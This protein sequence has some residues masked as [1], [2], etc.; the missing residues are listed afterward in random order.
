MAIIP[1]QFP[2]REPIADKS[3]IV[4]EPWRIWFRD[5]LET[6]QSQPVVTSPLV[7]LTGKTAS[8]T[9]TPFTTGTLAAGFYRFSYYATVTTAA[10]VSSSL[11]VTATWTD[12]GVVQTR[13]SAAMTGNTTAT[14]QSEVWPLH[15]DASSP[16]SYS[17][18]YASNVAATM[19]YALYLVLETVIAV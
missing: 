11:I 12:H 6:Q 13:S 15:I 4:R 2:V 10:A 16:V 18:T 9:L 7:P 8:V 3:G 14:N 1:A 5:L 19:V 17:T